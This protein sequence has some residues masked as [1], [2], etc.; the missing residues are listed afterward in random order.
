MADTA[1]EH[2]MVFAVEANITSWLGCRG[3]SQECFRSMRRI[4]A[5][6]FREGLQHCRFAREAVEVRST[7]PEVVP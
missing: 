3:A 1:A 4:G 2:D 6:R 5:S 7:A